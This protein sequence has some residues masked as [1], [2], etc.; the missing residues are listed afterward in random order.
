[1]SIYA[2]SYSTFSI[3]GHQR[4]PHLS[5]PQAR[6]RTLGGKVTQTDASPASRAHIYVDRPIGAMGSDLV[7]CLLIAIGLASALTVLFVTDI[8]SGLVW[9]GG[10]MAG[11]TLGALVGVGVLWRSSRVYQNAVECSVDAEMLNAAQ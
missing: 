4:L 11:Y 8:T 7:L 10:I 1:M 6:P 3:V 5:L 2:A 9:T